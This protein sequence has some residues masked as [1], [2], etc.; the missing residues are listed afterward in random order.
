MSC[1]F[2]ENGRNYRAEKKQKEKKKL[3]T[4]NDILRLYCA[5]LSLAKAKPTPRPR[6]AHRFF[7]F[8]IFFLLLQSQPKYLETDIF[9]RFDT[10][11]K[12]ERNKLKC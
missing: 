8:Y 2:K 4:E 3:P 12:R 1:D 10:K 6:D 9:E 7:F 5:I 11:A